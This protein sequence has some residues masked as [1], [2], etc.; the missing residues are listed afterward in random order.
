[1]RNMNIKPYE[2]SVWGNR[3]EYDALMRLKQLHS[4]EDYDPQ[5]NSQFTVQNEDIPQQNDDF[6]DF[7][8]LLILVNNHFPLFSTD[9]VDEPITQEINY[10]LNAEDT[11]I[12]PTYLD[13]YKLITVG[14][15]TMDS[16]LRAFEPKYVRNI[17]GTETLTFYLF[18]NYTNDE[19]ELVENPF[20]KLIVNERKIK[21]YY[22]NEWH[23]FIVRNVE[24]D[25]EENKFTYTC[26]DLATE[27]L[28]KSGFNLT[29][30][31]ELEN[32]Q[33]T[34]QALTR[35]ALNGSDWELQDDSPI[36]KQRTNEALY[37][38]QLLDNWQELV[39]EL[40]AIND[41]ILQI[42]EL[43]EDIN[44]SSVVPIKVIN[45]NDIII[46]N[47]T[48]YVYYS[49]LLNKEQ[50]YFQFIFVQNG[51]EIP[52]LDDH[53]TI[54]YNN[55]NV[56]EC[57]LSG[58]EYDEK[59]N[60]TFC[61]NKQLTDYRGDR[62]IR[63]QL[64][65]YDPIMDEP[66]TKWRRKSDG[67]EYYCYNDVE[68]LTS[69]ILENYIANGENFTDAAGWDEQE[70]GHNTK[71]TQFVYPNVEDLLDKPSD[72]NSLIAQMEDAS[73]TNG[74][75]NSYLKVQYGQQND[76]IINKG[77]VSNRSLIKQLYEKEK[78]IIA[79]LPGVKPEEEIN[80]IN[81]SQLDS[82]LETKYSNLYTFIAQYDY[83]GYTYKIKLEQD[84]ELKCLTE[85][86][87]TE[88][89]Q[90]KRGNTLFDG[91][92]LFMFPHLKKNIRD[93]YKR[94]NDKVIQSNKIYYIYH[95]QGWVLVEAPSDEN[96]SYYYEKTNETWYEATAACSA[97]IT[98]EEFLNNRYGIFI[99]SDIA[100]IYYFKKV[101]FYRQYEQDGEIVHIG[102]IPKSQI[103]TYYYY[104]D[105]LDIKR[106]KDSEEI[107]I[108]K[109]IGPSD[110]YEPIYGEGEHEFEKIRSISETES[111]RYNII[112]SICETFECWARFHVDHHPDGRIKL[113]LHYIYY[114][115]HNSEININKQ[116][117]NLYYFDNDTGLYKFAKVITKGVT[118]Y[119]RITYIGQNKKV[120]I[121]ETGQYPNWAGFKYGINLK[122]STRELDSAEITTKI[123]VK[124]NQCEYAKG[125]SCDITK[126]EENSIHENFAYNFRY[127]VQQG[128]LDGNLI[129]Y[130]LYDD[131]EGR[132]QHHSVGLYPRLAE[133]NKEL[134]ELNEQWTLMYS[135][136][137][138]KL[139]S[140]VDTYKLAYENAADKI[141]DENDAID[142]LVGFTWPELTGIANQ[143]V[144]TTDESPQYGTIYYNCN[145]DVYG[146]NSLYQEVSVSEDENPHALGYYTKRY[147]TLLEKVLREPS[148]NDGLTKELTKLIQYQKLYSVNKSLYD[149]YK[150]SLDKLKNDMTALETKL[151]I[152]A[153]KSNAIEAEFIAKYSRF[154][155]E[156]SW[157]DENYLDNNL[158]YFDAL[159]VLNTSAFPQVSYEFST[160]DLESLPGYSD[161]HFEVG[162]KTTVEDT[163]FFGWIIKYD[164]VLEYN[165]RT[166]ARENVI[167]S[168][169]TNNLDNPSE[170][171]IEIQNYKSQ[172]EDLFE[173]ITT[174][175][176]SLEYNEGKYAKAA[177]LVSS[178]G[179]INPNAIQTAIAGA[180]INFSNLSNSSTAFGQDGITVMDM[181]D[182]SKGIKLNGGGIYTTVDGG[183]TYQLA[184]NGDGLDAKSI[185]TGRI[186]TNLINIGN[187]DTPTFTWDIRGINAYSYDTIT[188]NNGDITITNYNNNKFVRFDQ[189]GLYGIN[190]SKL[191]GEKNYE[192]T[193]IDDVWNDAIFSLTWKGFTLRGE[194]NGSDCIE[195]SSDE[196]LRI[197]TQENDNLIEHIKLGNLGN[198]YGLRISDNTGNVQMVTGDDGKLWI[199]NALTV[200]NDYGAS[201]YFGP[202]YAHTFG[203][204]GYVDNYDKERDITK[205]Y[206]VYDSYNNIYRIAT[207]K[208]LNNFSENKF[209]E[210]DNTP[211]AVIRSN[212]DGENM[213]SVY[214][215]GVLEANGA[216]INGTIYA[217]NGE[218]SGELRAN[219][220]TAS[221]FTQNQ[222]SVTG[223]QMIFKTGY[224]IKQQNIASIVLD[225]DDNEEHIITRDA[226][227]YLCEAGTVVQ[228]KLVNGNELETYEDLS[229]ITKCKNL[230]LL[231][232]IDDRLTIIN[233][234]MTEDR[235]NNGN[236]KLDDN[237]KPIIIEDILNIYDEEY[238]YH[239]LFDINNNNLGYI[240][241]DDLIYYE[242][243]NSYNLSTLVS[244]EYDSALIIG[245]N[246]EIDPVICKRGV[247]NL[248]SSLLLP[249]GITLSEFKPGLTSKDDK[250]TTRLF[251]G[252]LESVPNKNLSG[253]GL[254]SD[255]VYLTGSIETNNG[256]AG[257][258]TRSGFKSNFLSEA[259]ENIAIWAGAGTNEASNPAEANFQVTRDGYLYAK[260][261]VFEG[262]I[263][264]SDIYTAR[265]HGW[266]RQGNSDKEN[267]TSALTIYNDN[268]NYGIIFKSENDEDDST[269]LII[270]SNSIKYG[271]IGQRQT[272]V[273][274]TN[275]GINYNG[276][277]NTGKINIQNDAIEFYEISKSDQGNINKLGQ[278]KLNKNSS[279]SGLLQIG[280]YESE[281]SKNPQNSKDQ[282]SIKSKLSI[283]NEFTLL[284]NEVIESKGI[285]SYSQS[286]GNMQFVPVN[287]GYNLYITGGGKE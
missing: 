208:E 242:N 70:S 215:N 238:N 74:L 179:S 144:A 99:A 269:H 40:H 30:D 126:A 257:I 52:L 230:M 282:L 18:H 279:N 246:A 109:S 115:L 220:I 124:P 59:G 256:D 152:I 58:V 111:N 158:Y 201:L 222:V 157:T 105:P 261:G 162:Q 181:A 50:D 14:S 245:S 38:F 22:E 234:A 149:Y 35:A 223:G 219:K 76:S 202:D 169:I 19:G 168:E 171:I 7:N 57:V 6:L 68:Y 75:Y 270:N 69:E 172:F 61:T 44:L 227:I 159:N 21:L 283:D 130:D 62:L 176:Q 12:I 218:F 182:T 151:E 80:K 240:K 190:Q 139:Q 2:I 134:C 125:G 263:Y 4:S 141:A 65:G 72:L 32:N 55:P 217:E 267:K 203:E 170:N 198:T 229:D 39:G 16:V 277:L 142:L 278:V 91:K 123:I 93:I 233:T 148:T 192:A 145:G 102:D 187:P 147:T 127:Y 117:E 266:S 79:I 122:S 101:Q 161:Y 114:R 173:R 104:Y 112:Q 9:I 11:N 154:I 118:Y 188:E 143:F 137:Y 86:G 272:L 204:P 165:I 231:G 84:E 107:I 132:I 94:T 250:I 27:E 150:L 110:E 90:D 103:I 15:D 98:R 29:F 252:N 259:K 195:M 209:F 31:T 274:I 131:E 82:D 239:E 81:L 193:S 249:Q 180:S 185:T 255:N 200:G 177:S 247:D 24:E 106:T 87:E 199:K 121:Y 77:I 175:T 211:Y 46:N 64:S 48:I 36:L 128:V 146:D 153:S 95:D 100:D 206:F 47:G 26:K 37:S 186:N 51:V 129:N 89:I 108:T 194:D 1:M 53:A 236:I 254:Y 183:V 33:G 49:N 135:I 197:L 63:K 225:L 42:H 140:N 156:G 10:R 73:N 207:Q 67:K 280:L 241:E 60:P 178:D 56:L 232:N 174:A 3:Q 25:S 251:L 285:V 244:Q 286:G 275:D 54:D 214:S 20:I 212:T 228:V 268:D 276:N 260:Q 213:F 133:I 243:N 120:E 265:V 17:N 166:P 271:D 28:G 196:G 45:T 34:A 23:D 226:Y 160:V 273:S 8:D 5:S 78:Y 184:L 119:G 116:Q 136:S 235:D 221:V 13:E 83:D 191:S 258:D 262:D 284:Q 155:Q 71:V 92:F 66:I 113:G 164:P 85:D 189:Y 205:T 138:P 216:V 96:I 97:S 167:I 281:I 237:G 41:D 264:S 88:L 253:Y 210:L 163:E 287:G 224:K 43:D 248:N